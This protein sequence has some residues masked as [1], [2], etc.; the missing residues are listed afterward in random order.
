[1]IDPRASYIVAGCRSPIGRYLGGLAS[2]S[3]IELASLSIRSAIERTP[4]LS[5]EII[6]DVYMGQ[7]VSAGAGQAPARQALLKAGL[8]PK[9]GAITIN[10]V[11]GSGLMAVMLADQAIRCGD[12]RAIIA[13]G[14]ESMSQAP[15]LLFGGR[16][17]WKYGPQTMQDAVAWDGLRC[18][19]GCSMMGD[20]ADHTASQWSVSRE[21]QDQFALMSHK[22]AIAATQNGFFQSETAPV[23]KSDFP[24]LKNDVIVDE[25]PRADSS[26]EKLSQLKPTFGAQGTV[27][28]GNASPLSDGSAAVVV[29]DA[30]LAVQSESPWSFKIRSHAVYAAE[31]REIFVAPVGAVKLAAEKA[32]ISVSDIDLFELNEAFASQS[33]ACIRQL[34]IAMERV[35]IHGGAIALGHPLGCSGTRV[36]VTLIH[37]LLR[38]ERRLGCA[39]LC[40]GGGEAV[41]MVIERT[42]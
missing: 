29:V 27:T 8:A 1:M 41:A 22:K 13:A 17:G 31:P 35:N 14:V 39:S 38:T 23:T 37:A 4:G 18:A 34:G 32:K 24:A 16:S 10:K 30:D 9:T 3:S 20:Y 42:K 2:L 7:V 28:A 21:D 15:H 5:K 33:L 26:L 36:L 6:E 19:M 11:C 12:R 40:L 25:S